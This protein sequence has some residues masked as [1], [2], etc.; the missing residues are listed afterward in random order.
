MKV[1]NRKWI[2]LV[3]ALGLYATTAH[4]GT[5]SGAI[6]EEVR[7]TDTGMIEIVVNK[8]ISGSASCAE[9]KN[10]MALDISDEAGDAVLKIAIAAHLSGKTVKLSGKGTCNRSSSKEDLSWIRLE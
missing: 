5:V 7:V 1:F 2:L 10:A 6:V 9:N 4:A 3:L 8:T